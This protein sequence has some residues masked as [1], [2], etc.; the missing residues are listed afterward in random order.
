VIP[1]K[2][3][4]N[5]KLTFGSCN[6]I[7]GHEQNEIFNRIAE[8]KSDV[9]IWL[10]DVVYLDIEGF[11]PKFQFPGEARAR[12]KFNINKNDRNYKNLRDSTPVIGVWDDHD[13]GKDNSGKTFPFKNLSRELWLDFIDE[14]KDSLRRTRKGGIYES[15]Y[16]GDPSKV[17]I[18][19]VDGRFSRDDYSLMKSDEIDL[20]GAEQWEWLENELKENQAEYVVIGSGVQVFPDDRL[21]PETWYKQSREKLL[22]LIRRYKVSG[23]ILLSGD[24]HYA[25]IMKYPCKQ[26]VGYELYEFTSSGLTH[27]AS[28]HVPIVAGLFSQLF[29]KTYND[30]ED[31]YFERNFG[32]VE[33]SFGETTN[34]VKLEARNYYGQPVLSKDIHKSE[35]QFNE[36]ILDENAY[37]VADTNRFA[38][39]FS[40][41]GKVLLQGKIYIWAVILIIA[42]VLVLLI[43]AIRFILGVLFWIIKTLLGIRKTPKTKASKEKQN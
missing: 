19:L 4:N 28:S 17:K 23:V 24:V 20:L 25:E 18:I 31:K 12:E 6:A 36:S 13:Y 39:F 9:W 2:D 14:P 16:L 30:V 7:L 22:R 11:P 15:Y 32:V 42:F 33:F 26:K 3:P 35:L 8:V 1:V 41:L 29:P 34:K 40:H 38:R 21:L 27:H 10:G 5:I 43:T 37:C